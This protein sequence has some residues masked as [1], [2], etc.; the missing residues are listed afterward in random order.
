[1]R[2]SALDLAN[3]WVQLGLAIITFIAVIVALFGQKF[4]SWRNRPVAKVIFGNFEPYSLVLYPNSVLTMLFRLKI[5]NVGKSI[6]KNCRVKIISAIPEN[7]PNSSL[8]KEPD[9]LKWSNAPI[10]SRY[11]IHK[12]FKNIT[13]EGGWEFCDFFKVKTTE[14]K[15]FFVSA[16]ERNF[17]LVK[18]GKYEVIIEVSGDN[19]KPTRKKIS[20]ITPFK[21][22]WS[23]PTNPA[24]VLAG[25]TGITEI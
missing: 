12:E 7:I 21:V 10:D 3:F 16:G 6:I 13:P 4:W 2:E 1:M 20:I 24:F 22:D 9:V 25:V 18:D 8:I 23:N 14:E 19:L 11:Q 17:E 15:L 5:V